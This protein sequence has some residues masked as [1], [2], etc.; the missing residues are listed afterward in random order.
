MEAGGIE[1]PSEDTYKK[2]STCVAYL[3]VLAGGVADKQATDPA[4]LCVFAPI[5]KA[6]IGTILSLPTLDSK[7][8]RKVP[9]EGAT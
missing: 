4:S 9:E 6:Q 8:N 7:T 3:L 1:P 2:P 5:C